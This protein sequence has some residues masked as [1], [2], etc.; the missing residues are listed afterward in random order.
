M[1]KKKPKEKCI[2]PEENQNIIDDLR[3]IQQYK[4]GVSKTIGNILLEN[5][6]IQPTKLRQKLR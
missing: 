4:N 5:I 2:S 1:I 3:L 6:P